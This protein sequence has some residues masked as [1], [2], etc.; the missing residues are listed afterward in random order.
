VRLSLLG[1]SATVWPVVPTQ[2]D[3]WWWMWSSLWNNN[4]QGKPK[5]SEKT[6]PSFTLSGTNPTWPDLGSNPGAAYLLPYVIVE[7]SMVRQCEI[8]LFSPWNEVTLK[9][10]GTKWSENGDSYMP[11]NCVACILVWFNEGR[12]DY[13]VIQ[14]ISEKEDMRSEFVWIITV[15]K[16][17]QF[18]RG[19]LTVEKLW[20]ELVWT[21][22]G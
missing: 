12:W 18:G 9:M 20:S 17:K 14:H 8:P 15:W 13:L 3:R 11:R 4:W 1:T 6:Y 5:Y 16:K 22:S 7:H 21:V 19:G 10:F 2:D